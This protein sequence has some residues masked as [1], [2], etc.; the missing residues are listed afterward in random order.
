MKVCRSCG[1]IAFLIGA[2]S[3]EPDVDVGMGANEIKYPM[4]SRA[5]EALQWQG[6][7]LRRLTKVLNLVDIA[8]S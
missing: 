1:G 6:G 5:H 3:V 8:R 4:L 2:D 7:T